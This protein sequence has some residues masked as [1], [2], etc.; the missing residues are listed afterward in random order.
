MPHTHA[1]ARKLVNERYSEI[2]SWRQVAKKYY[3]NVSFAV[4]R[5]FAVGKTPHISRALQ[6]KLNISRA[7]PKPRVRDGVRYGD[8]PGRLGDQ[9]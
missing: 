7:K 4:L 5:D 6:K 8:Q 2:Q 1:Q 9:L 3:P